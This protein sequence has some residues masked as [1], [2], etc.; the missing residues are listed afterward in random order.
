MG[1]AFLVTHPASA[2]LGLAQNLAQNL[3]RVGLGVGGA[4][5]QVWG[6]RAPVGPE[7][8]WPT[9]AAGCAVRFRQLPALSPVLF[10]V[11]VKNPQKALLMKRKVCTRI[12]LHTDAFSFYLLIIAP[13]GS[14][15]QYEEDRFLFNDWSEQSTLVPTRAWCLE[16]DG[17]G[18]GTLGEVPTLSFYISFIY[19]C[20]TRWFECR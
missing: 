2:A 12:L 6:A 3:A 19:L 4:A 14:A 5:K 17:Q 10:K 18:P 9:G 1:R 13:Y 8:Q 16:A 11:T 20:L 15:S 7:P